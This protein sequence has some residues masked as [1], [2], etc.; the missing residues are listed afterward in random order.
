MKNVFISSDNIITSLG[1]TTEENITKIKNNKTGIYNIEDKELSPSAFH[2]SLINTDELNSKF[3]SINSSNNFTRF[4]KLSILS[5]KDA[6][7]KTT[8]D[9]KNKKTLF[10]LSTTK[11]NIDL[12]EEKNK[13]IF[14]ENRLYLSNTAKLIHEYFGSPNQPVVISNACISGVLAIIIGSRLIRSGQFENVV[15]TG[16]DIVSKFVVSGFISFQSLSSGPCRPFDVSR[17][18]LSLGEGCGTIIL[19]SNK[20]YLSRQTEV[21]VGG[22]FSSNDA[23]H[24]SGPSRTGEGLLLAIN[25]TIEDTES[26]YSK[27]IDYISAHGTATPYNDEM[28]SVAITRAGLNEVPVNSFKGYW[29]HTLGAAGIIES[30]DGIYSLRN[31]FL[32]KTAGFSEIGVTNKINVIDKHEERQINNCLKIASGFGGCNAGVIFHKL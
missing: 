10:I 4:E 11:G 20:N 3:N 27:N 31:D 7:S 2:A 18:G 24:I 14:G 13:M 22:G 8:V 30:I 16:T 15:I 32:F 21:I 12:L 6:L 5:I 17:D 28:E 23:N 19:T 9:I 26:D 29:G 1:F 25:K